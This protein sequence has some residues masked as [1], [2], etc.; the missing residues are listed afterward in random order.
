MKAVK[1]NLSILLT[2]AF[3]LSMFYPPTS[4]SAVTQPLADVD[5]A[6]VSTASVN[7]NTFADG[8]AEINLT[9]VQE[10]QNTTRSSS[11]I[12]TYQTTSL[13]FLAN[14][15]NEKNAILS[16]ISQVRAGGGTIYDEDWYFGSSC[17][18]YISITYTTR[19]VSNGTEANP[20]C[21]NKALC[22]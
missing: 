21:D 1:R 13:T 11:N 17:Y 12:N 15:Q 6:F 22:K 18:A 20:L 9:D 4:A 19:D 3:L 2:P 5:S 14:S 8:F 10:V 16:R 7:V